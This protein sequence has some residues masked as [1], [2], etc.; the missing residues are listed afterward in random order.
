MVRDVEPN[1]GDVLERPGVR[2][3]L[4]RFE[5]QEANALVVCD[6]NRLAGSRRQ[7]DTLLE[8]LDDRGVALV[9]LEPELDTSTAEG[10]ELAHQLEIVRSERAKLGERGGSP[11]RRGRWPAR[12][13]DLRDQGESLQAIADALNQDQVAPPGGFK[14]R[15]RNVRTVLEQNGEAGGNV[16]PLG[17][18]PK[19]RR[20]GHARAE[21]QARGLS[22]E[23]F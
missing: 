11:G 21:G 19:Q 15:P 13:V 16:V 12:I 22:P 7:L 23:T 14:W 2:Y 8:R 20:V 4:E 18:R 9:A 10:R 1:G 5:S 3:A 6:V 17:S